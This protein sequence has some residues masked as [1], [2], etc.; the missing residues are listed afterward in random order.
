MHAAGRT[1]PF[2]AADRGMR[3]AQ[4]ST[5]LQHREAAHHLDRAPI[6]VG[7]ARNPVPSPPFVSHHS[8]DQE[9][10]DS[11]QE[12]ETNTPGDDEER[13]SRLWRRLGS[14]QAGHVTRVPCQQHADLTPA[15]DI[16]ED[17]D[18]GQKKSR[19]KQE[20]LYSVVPGLYAEPKSK[21]DAGM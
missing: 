8:R 6:R 17:R 5:C 10:H 2:A 12:Y 3:H 19:G 4:Q 9:K 15:G 1:T 7:D 16:P 14:K 21:S 20:R 11:Y 13:G 18:D